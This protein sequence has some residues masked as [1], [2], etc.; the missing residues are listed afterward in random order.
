MDRVPPID[1]IEHVGQLRG[2]DSN[3]AVGRRW[4]DEAALLQ[5]FGVERH[6]ETIMPKN[7]DQ[8]TS[9]A[10]KD[11]EIA[12]RSVR[13]SWAAASALSEIA[14]FLLYEHYALPRLRPRAESGL[15]AGQYDGPTIGIRAKSLPL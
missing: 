5:P 12:R 9:G 6:A 15:R 1:P 14:R 7:L 11:V 3:Y 10:S 8:V 13:P 4:P 2:R